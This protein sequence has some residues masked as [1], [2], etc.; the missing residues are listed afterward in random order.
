MRHA[1]SPR[2]A[3]QNHARRLGFRGDDTANTEMVFSSP[4]GSLNAPTNEMPYGCTLL[5]TSTTR[6]TSLPIL[7]IRII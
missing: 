3:N 7:L 4:N 1:A 2:L 6:Y 5:Q